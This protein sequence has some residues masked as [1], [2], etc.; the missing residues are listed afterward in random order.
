[1]DKNISEV[2]SSSAK[3][4]VMVDVVPT[5]E[6]VDYNRIYCFRNDPNF[7]FFKAN[8]DLNKKHIKD[9]ENALGC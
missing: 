5:I 8:R 7:G 3:G 9:I 1:M 4:S 2:M 6:N